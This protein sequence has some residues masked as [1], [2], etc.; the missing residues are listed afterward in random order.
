MAKYETNLGFYMQQIKQLQYCCEQQNTWIHSYH[1]ATGKY[2]A[3]KQK[4][5][6]VIT[7]IRSNAESM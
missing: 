1:S 5:T 4:H 6:F 3:L 2:Q 7:A